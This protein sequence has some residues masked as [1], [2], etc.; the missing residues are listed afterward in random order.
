MNG[1]IKCFIKNKG[2]GFISV[3]NSE[4][5][6]FHI[7]Q[8]QSE[9]EPR[10]G[11]GVHF[12]PQTGQD[13]KLIAKS[14]TVTTGDSIKLNRPYYGKPTYRTEYVERASGLPGGCAI[15]ILG[16]FGL[17]IGAAF[18]GF[19]GGAIGLVLGII[20]GA[21]D[22]TST[23]KPAVTRQV[24]VT[25]QCIKCGGKGQV[26]SEI[27]GRTGFQCQSC[28]NFWTQGEHICIKCSKKGQVISKINGRK[29]WHCPSCGVYWNEGDSTLRR[30]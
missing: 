8:F 25:S 4:D 28:G 29:K 20:W 7:S 22:Q 15:P 3:P 17:L 21:K 19:I 16:F 1:I 27:D 13:G 12:L 18:F 11:D 5:Y 2:Y 23:E 30:W 26:T 24:E 10:E 9:N 14:V 6:F